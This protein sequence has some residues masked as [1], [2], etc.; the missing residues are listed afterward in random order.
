MTHLLSLT[1]HPLSEARE[2]LTHNHAPTFDF[3]AHRRTNFWLD[4]LLDNCLNPTK[5]ETLWFEKSKWIQI[6]GYKAPFKVLGELE[7]TLSAIAALSD[8]L[9]I[10]DGFFGLYND[11]MIDEE[12][13]SEI[14]LYT[15]ILEAPIGE[16]FQEATILILDHL[17]KKS[18]LQKTMSF[19]SDLEIISLS[20]GVHRFYINVKKDQDNFTKTLLEH[21][22]VLTGAF[23]HLKNNKY[24]QRLYKEISGPA[25][26]PNAP[27]SMPDCSWAL[28]SDDSND[29]PP[30]KFGIFIRKNGYVRGGLFGEVH[31]DDVF[32]PH[33]DIDLFWIDSTIR[34]TGLGTKVM[35]FAFEHLKQRDAKVIELSTLDYQAPLFYEKMGFSRIHTDPKIVKT[36][37]GKLNNSYIY[38][39]VL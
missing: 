34:G 37:D 16:K 38:R 9:K 24:E 36:R 22:Y 21:G 27:L 31:T 26:Y 3:P 30:A 4:P 1:T 10:N 32:T 20:K 23:H 14:T 13:M 6:P 19:L 39:K 11:D 15:P 12:T 8:C 25:L 28:E 29:I 17:L 5:G 7:I 35:N 2:V 18:G 33:A